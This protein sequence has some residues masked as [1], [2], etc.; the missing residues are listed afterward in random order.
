M[1]K[2]DVV[3]S[4][5]LIP[6]AFFFY[7]RAIGRIVHDVPLSKKF[8]TYTVRLGKILLVTSCL[9]LVDERANIIRN[10]DAVRRDNTETR[11]HMAKESDDFV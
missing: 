10:S 4:S 5:G 3:S 9:S 2:T 1:A 7:Q 8:I 6:G 11:T